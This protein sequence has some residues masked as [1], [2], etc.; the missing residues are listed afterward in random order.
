MK[1][2]RLSFTTAITRT[3]LSS[4]SA[5]SW[6]PKTLVILRSNT[7][8]HCQGVGGLLP[9]IKIGGPLPRAAGRG[10]QFLMT[11]VTPHEIKRRGEQEWFVALNWETPHTNYLIRRPA[12]MFKL[13]DSPG[14]SK[15][16][17][18]ANCV[19][20]AFKWET[21]HGRTQSPIRGEDTKRNLKHVWYLFSL[22]KARRKLLT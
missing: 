8:L 12:I 18:I 9:K 13:R 14:R 11:S 1:L 16:P 19:A 5:L 7:F 20:F 10:D 4:P 21:T 6:C 2:W 15:F 17:P 3:S 22:V